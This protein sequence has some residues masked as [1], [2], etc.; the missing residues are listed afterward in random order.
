MVSVELIGAKQMES[1]TRKVI[2]VLR[3]PKGTAL[4][5]GAEVIRQEIEDTAPRS[6]KIGGTYG[7]G[8]AADHISMRHLRRTQDD[9]EVHIGP[10]ED[11]WYLSF[12]EFGTPTQPARAPMRRAA[13]RRFKDAEAEY[14]RHLRRG[15]LA[16]L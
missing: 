1:R 6:N 11:F 10:E 4:L 12:V 2:R 9:H 14:T 15:V 16:I 13:R 8:H 7:R 3:D 5:A